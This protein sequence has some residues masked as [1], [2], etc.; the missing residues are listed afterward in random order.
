MARKRYK[1]EEIV[2]DRMQLVPSSYPHKP[3]S[4]QDWQAEAPT[5]LSVTIRK[6]KVSDLL[7]APRCF[8]YVSSGSRGRRSVTLA[9]NQLAGLEHTKQRQVG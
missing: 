5:V 3:E 7:G 1:T 8:V 4:E 9:A 2:T 6:S